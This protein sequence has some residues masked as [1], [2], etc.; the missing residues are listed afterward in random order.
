MTDKTPTAS[1]RGADGLW[2][3][4]EHREEWQADLR[5]TMAWYSLPIDCR[6]EEDL[7]S[8]R[9]TWSHAAETATLNSTREEAT[10]HIRTI[11]RRLAYL[12]TEQD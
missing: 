2:P 9:K 11:D 6:N 3:A 12:A 7:Y 10:D 5:R 4:E 8:W 1:Y